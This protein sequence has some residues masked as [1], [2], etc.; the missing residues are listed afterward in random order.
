M[1]NLK[2]VDKLF[3]SNRDL[4]TAVPGKSL[5][6]YKFDRG[7]RY[8]FRVENKYITLH[9]FY[10]VKNKLVKD[11]LIMKLIDLDLFEDEEL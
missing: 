1:F 7:D 6:I 11:K 5:C 2:L 9:R 3:E 10:F 4:M 8:E